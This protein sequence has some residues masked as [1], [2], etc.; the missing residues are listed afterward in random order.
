MIGGIV[1]LEVVSAAVTASAFQ[2]GFNMAVVAGQVIAVV[3]GAWLLI[4]S[5]QARQSIAN[6]ADAQKMASEW[7]ENYLAERQARVDSDAE[8]L[9]QRALK[10]AA[11][12]EAE[13]ARLQITAV[14]TALIEI[15]KTVTK[16]LEVLDKIDRHLDRFEPPPQPLTEVVA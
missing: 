13:A 16:S 12:S 1:A 8:A 7:R 14:M 15:Q 3:V 4:R 10:H 11:K 6:A 5:R 9:E 2:S